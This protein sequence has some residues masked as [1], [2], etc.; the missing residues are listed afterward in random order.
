MLCKKTHSPDPGPG[1]KGQNSTV[2]EHGYA[3]YQIKGNGY[4]SNIQEH[5]L[6]LHAPRTPGGRRLF[7]SESIHVAY[8]INWNG[9]KSTI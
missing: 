1:S 4:C 3:A 5:I 8:S 7:F 2:S 6:S 9:A